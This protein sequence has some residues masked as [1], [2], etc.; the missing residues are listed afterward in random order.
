[1]RP[2]SL[3]QDYNFQAVAELPVVEI[4]KIGMQKRIDEAHWSQ[5]SWQRNLLGLKTG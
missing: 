3:A 2:I 1:L 4:V 5:I